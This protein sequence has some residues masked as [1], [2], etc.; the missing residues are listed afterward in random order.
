M[1]SATTVAHESHAPL[2]E[3]VVVYGRAEQAIGYAGSASEGL[4]G[5]ADI[6]LPPLL[7]VGELVEAVP[8]MVATQHSG[9]GKA[10]QYF[11]RGFNLD[12]GTDFSAHAGG[13]PLN[14]R[15]HGHGHGYL[16]LNFLIPEMVATTRYVKGPYHAGKGDFSSAG[17]VDFQ[18]YERLPE[19]LL[20]VGIGADGFRRALTAGSVEMA[21]G[22]LTGAVDLT[23]YDGPWQ[24]DEDLTQNRLQA[25]YAFD[26]AGARVVLDGQ[27]YDSAW[28]ST[29]Q[30][31]HR[32]VRSGL[33]D[34]LG[35][36]DPDLGGSTERYALSGSVELETWKL[37]AYLIDYDFGLY[38]N[39]TYLLDN[40][41]DG[42]EFEQRDQRRVYG[43]LVEGAHD[44][45]AG[46][47]S[48]ILR[49]GLD[50][51]LDDIDR[52]GLYRTAAR[53]RNGAVR[54]DA[55]EERSAG[56]Y[57]ELEVA[58]S[59]RLRGTL[60]LRGDYYDWDVKAFREANGGSGDDALV[61]P[62]LS[63]AYRFSEGLEG[64]ANWGRGFHSNDVRGVTIEVDPV[65][66]SRMD[67]VDA[68]VESQGAELGLRLERGDRFNVSLVGFWLE[69]DSELV[70]VGDAGATETNGATERRGIEA[71]GFWQATDWL[72]LDAAYT[73]TDAQFVREQSGGDKVP[74]AVAST[75]S[76]GMNAV[77]RNGFSASARLRYLGEAPLVEDNS[78]RAADSLLVNAGV[79][80][81]RSA[82]ELRI[83]LF[84]VLDS[85]DY[86]ISYYYASRLAGEPADGVED[87]HFHPLEPRTLRA[88][89]TW[90]L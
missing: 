4:V 83:D 59:E 25:R 69:L 48:A 20:S 35:F 65:T 1:T 42:D 45:A 52:V 57:G 63:L 27:G 28:N 58:L 24:I 11:L 8:G 64:Y 70:F 88:S 61:S 81:R 80:Y 40:P 19:T 77:W 2:V 50:A 3:E 68:V 47:R 72:A 67:P 36:I 10:N 34:E 41:I 7:R 30:I 87:V 62:K 9:T 12:H 37:T 44:V 55:V 17:A 39:F 53:V 38:S 84:N 79:A 15:T 32:A 73:V 26:V 33:I 16:D 31:P 71:S 78:V 49:W 76:L 13:V 85:S 56:I 23:R 29:D 43:L 51:R 18:F 90:H 82:L 22:V 86:D 54:Q 21:R 66:G 6:R 60:G 75:F 74:G 5:Y 46:N 14:M 89:L